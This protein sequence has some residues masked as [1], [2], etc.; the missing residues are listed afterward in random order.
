MTVEKEILTYRDGIIRLLEEEL[1]ILKILKKETPYSKVSLFEIKTGWIKTKSGIL[2]PLCNHRI[3]FECFHISVLEGFLVLL[4]DAIQFVDNYDYPIL[5]FLLRTIHEFSFKYIN[6]HFL[7]SFNPT[8]EEKIRFLRVIIDY[9]ILA[10]NISEYKKY[11]ESLYNEEKNKLN[12][13]EQNKIEGCLIDPAKYKRLVRYVEELYNEFLKA[14]KPLQF[15]NE[16]KN[17]EA[18]SLLSHF[19]H[20]DP[21]LIKGI[22]EDKNNSKGRFYAMFLYS[23]INAINRIGEF[24]NNAKI[25]LKIGD[26]NENFNRIWEL[27]KSYYYKQQ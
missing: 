23:T 14:V 27:S 24:I 10:E 5:N 9:L 21:L 19:I 4:K 3:L 12:K 26:F 1:E 2:K 7:S 17:K 22:M 6:T 16:D 20:A 8:L 15:I 11:A 18:Y 13:K 25:S